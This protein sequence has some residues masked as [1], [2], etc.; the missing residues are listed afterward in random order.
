MPSTLGMSSSIG[1]AFASAAS[2]AVGALAAGSSPV[3]KTTAG[4]VSTDSA[5]AAVA[6][7]AGAD[8]PDTGATAG[9]A[10]G[11]AAASDCSAGAALCPHAARARA[12]NTASS[13]TLPAFK[14]KRIITSLF[15]RARV[16]RV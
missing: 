2:V 11:F 12:Q 3:G 1:L 9:A 7:S 5:G 4:V 16:R 14:V 8:S 6:R 10:V 15:V 13:I